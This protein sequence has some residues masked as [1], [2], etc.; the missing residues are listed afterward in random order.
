MINSIRDRMCLAKN[1]YLLAHPINTPATMLFKYILLN[2]DLNAVRRLK[3]DVD[4][5]TEYFKMTGTTF[6]SVIDPNFSNS[7][8]GGKFIDKTTF[9]GSTLPA[10]IMLNCEFANP[11][12]ELP[13]EEDWPKWEHLRG[14]KIMYHDSLEIPEDFAKSTFQFRLSPPSHFVIAVNV[15]VLCFKYYK[16]IEDCKENKVDPDVSYF[17]KQFEFANF[18]DDLIDIFIMNVLQRVFSRPTDSVDAIADSMLVP[19]R[20]CTTNMKRQGVEGIVEFVNLLK[21]GALKPQDF[22]ATHWFGD[23]SIMGMV[24][25]NCYRLVSLPN[26]SRYLWLRTIN[27][28]PYLSMLIA[29]TRSFIDGPFKETFDFRCREIWNLKI[30]PISM[31]GAVTN[32]G[33]K[34]VIATWKANLGA[35]LNGDDVILPRAG[36]Q[37]R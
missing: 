8:A 11:I 5:Y 13:F 34:D 26:T 6:R 22:L 10:E 3:T 14:I 7:I 15:P 33:V 36:H 2:L 16:Y 23:K 1:R 25:E 35:Y 24:R 29:C 20:F 27:D 12:N 19:L 17:L 18:F 37:W 9:I 31:P 32:P 28:F 30:R 21:E 4:R